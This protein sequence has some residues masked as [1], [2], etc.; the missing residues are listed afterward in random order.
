MF[1]NI[2]GAEMMVNSKMRIRDIQNLV[3][4][5]PT[6]GGIIAELSGVF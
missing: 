6:Y 3:V 4:V 2:F 5:H 1:G